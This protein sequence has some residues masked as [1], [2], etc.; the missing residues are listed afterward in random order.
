MTNGSSQD[1]CPSLPGNA[2]VTP[3]LLSANRPQ[4]QECS[5]EDLGARGE[6]SARQTLGY[7][8]LRASE[9]SLLGG[10]PGTELPKLSA[11]AS[12]SGRD[13]DG[14]RPV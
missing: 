4:R 7:L 2:A 5:K 6:H 13:L 3:G 10:P 11:G 9:R 1:R 8:K 12:S 14:A